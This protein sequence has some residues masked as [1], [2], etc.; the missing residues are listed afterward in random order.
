MTTKVQRRAL[1][2]MLDHGGEIMI[3]TGHKT[4]RLA[5]TRATQ[6]PVIA[7]SANLLHGLKCNLFIVPVGIPWDDH[8]Y[9]I[10]DA[11]RKAAG[12]QR[13]EDQCPPLQ[14]PGPCVMR[15][16]PS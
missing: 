1:W 9:R 16:I 10:T 6:Q 7:G 5:K 15:S 3:V 12:N 14:E 2:W 13:P 8:L 11:G 4:T